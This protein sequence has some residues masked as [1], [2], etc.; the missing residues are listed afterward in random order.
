MKIYLLFKL[1]KTIIIS[2]NLYIKK[3]NNITSIYKNAQQQDNEYPL[4]KLT[5]LNKYKSKT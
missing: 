4:I 2:L 5:V 1:N 3:T